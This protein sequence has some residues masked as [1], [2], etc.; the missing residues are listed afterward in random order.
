MNKETLWKECLEDFLGGACGKYTHSEYLVV[1]GGIP[2]VEHKL[3]ASRE[4]LTWNINTKTKEIIEVKHLG[5]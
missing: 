5:R 2:T 1:L 4:T 3:F